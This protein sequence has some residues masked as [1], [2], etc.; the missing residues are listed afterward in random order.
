MNVFDQLCGAQF[1][2][3][4]LGTRPAFGK[5]G[6]AIWLTD[7]LTA[8]IDDGTQWVSV[9]ATSTFASLLLQEIA[10]P[11]T[12]GTGFGKFYLGT[13]KIA[14]LLDSTGSFTRLGWFRNLSIDKVLNSISLLS[15]SG[16]ALT[17]LNY[18]EVEMISSVGSSSPKVRIKIVTTM[19]LDFDTMDGFL[20]STFV[21]NAWGNARP[22]YIYLI[23][24]DNTFAGLRLA[25]SFN[26]TLKISPVAAQ[27][28]WSPLGTVSSAIT[29]PTDSDMFISATALQGD[30]R[31]THAGKPVVRLGA[32]QVTKN[33]SDLW[34]VIAFSKG[35]DG[36]IENPYSSKTFILPPGQHNA[37]SGSFFQGAGTPVFSP[38]ANIKA[39][40]TLNPNTGLCNFIFST[41]DATNVLVNGVNANPLEIPLPYRAVFTTFT[42]TIFRS[43][44]GGLVRLAANTQTVTCRFSDTLGSGGWTNIWLHKDTVIPL[45][46]VQ[47]SQFSN[48]SNDDVENIE[49]NYK[50]F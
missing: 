31:T 50:A 20:A 39:L 21:A 34:A 28:A 27:N 12:P 36:L 3:F 18:G 42:S 35:E 8:Q 26:P 43:F 2:N 14:R 17:T 32:C 41:V 22:L 45:V 44:G 9:S 46:L 48:T 15:E 25:V 19:N 10:T 24:L 33:A 29:L 47:N 13:D 7:I 11:A 40:Y 38:L 5:P 23:N 16:N 6:R 30:P 49:I 4:V 37:G 1:E